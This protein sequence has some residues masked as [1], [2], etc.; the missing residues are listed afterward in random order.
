MATYTAP[1][2]FGETNIMPFD[3]KTYAVRKRMPGWRVCADPKPPFVTF[4]ET[5]WNCAKCE[6]EKTFE[7]PVN[8]DDQFQYQF[9]FDDAI[10]EDPADP[11][12]GWQDSGTGENPFYMNA[13]ILDCECN[14]IGLDLVDDFASDYGVAFDA[15]GGSYQWLNVDIGLIPT[16]VCCF[17]IQIEHYAPIE[18][19]PV[20]DQNIV[21]GPFFRNDT[22]GC[23]CN[24]SEDKT[25]LICGAYKKTDCWGR[26]YDIEFGA[27]GTTFSDCVRVGASVIYLGT[28]S[29]STFDGE[30]EI[31]TTQKKRYKLDLQGVPPMIAEW[32]SNILASNGVLTIGDYSIDRS[33][34]DAVGSFDRSIDRVEMFHGS[35]E[36][37]I[38]CE[39]QNF[40]CN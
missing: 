7:L 24:V 2:Q 9:Q 19:V 30:V 18:G 22:A 17:Y 27:S 33:K 10:N 1:F 4:G 16:E 35:V 14:S 38:V 34:G 29:E 26:R 20:N 5:A 15:V 3:F 12:Y 23:G 36:F 6:G 21:A 31:A 32:V 37:S 11:I 25:L 39:I 13:R 8:T 40:G 28:T